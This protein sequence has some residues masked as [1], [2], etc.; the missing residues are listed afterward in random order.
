MGRLEAGE[1][2]GCSHERHGR[3]RR[4]LRD[5]LANHD[6]CPWQ[7]EEKYKMDDEYQLEDAGTRCAS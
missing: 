6:R 1:E 4:D 3:P 7:H 5:L 2:P